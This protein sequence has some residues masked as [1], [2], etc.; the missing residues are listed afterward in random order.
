MSNPLIPIFI[1][2]A[3]TTL[4]YLQKALSIPSKRLPF[5]WN[6]ECAAQK[7]KDLRVVQ[8]IWAEFRQPFFHD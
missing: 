7:V 5:G 1:I 6:N 4:K 8:D 2:H 3:D